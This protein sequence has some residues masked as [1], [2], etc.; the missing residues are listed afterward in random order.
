MDLNFLIPSLTV[1]AV[2]EP[3]VGYTRVSTSRGTR[4]LCSSYSMSG[5]MV[6]VRVNDAEAKICHSCHDV[7]RRYANI[8][9]T[10]CTTTVLAC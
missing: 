1:I 2:T 10:S 5:C 4:Y 9:I 6:S 8:Y 7:C 3:N